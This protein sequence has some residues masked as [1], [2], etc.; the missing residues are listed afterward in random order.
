MAAGK[1]SGGR[2]SR[3]GARDSGTGKFIPVK[4]AERRPAQTQKERIP[5]PG[6]GDTGRGKQ[7]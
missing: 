4:E 1:G 3:I 6:F 5:L 2:Q 7:K